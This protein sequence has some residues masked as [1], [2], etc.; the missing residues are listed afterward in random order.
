MYL[1]IAGQPVIVLNSHKAA[2]DL[3][4]KRAEI[5]SGRA[6]NIVVAEIISGGL[7]FPLMQHNDL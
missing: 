3:L 4:D 2:N 6:R 7:D 1:K 5:Y